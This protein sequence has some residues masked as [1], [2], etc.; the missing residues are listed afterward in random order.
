MVTRLALS[1]VKA[2]GIQLGNPEPA[3]INRAKAAEQASSFAP[4]H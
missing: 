4:A 2:R 3:K 1:A